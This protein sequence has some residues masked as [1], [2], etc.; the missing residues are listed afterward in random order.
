MRQTQILTFLLTIIVIYLLMYASFA[1]GSTTFVINGFLSG[2]LTLFYLYLM[3]SNGGVISP[4][5]VFINIIK[6]Y[7][8]VLTPTDWL[9]I[10][11]GLA[12]LLYNF[13]RSKTI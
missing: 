1:G 3:H 11:M 12:V 7:R 13:S 9:I 5:H 10:V 8:N 4:A 2:S 6:D